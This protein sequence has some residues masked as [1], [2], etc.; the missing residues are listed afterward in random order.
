MEAAYDA[1]RQTTGNGGTQSKRAK[2]QLCHAGSAT[3]HK[4]KLRET[5]GRKT[6]GLKR[7]HTP[8]QPGR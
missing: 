6:R 8:C 3:G 4:G 1:H 2:T 5:A 7:A